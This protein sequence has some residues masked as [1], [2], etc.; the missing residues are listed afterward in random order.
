MNQRKKQTNKKK[1]ERHGEVTVSLSGSSVHISFWLCLGSSVL[2]CA[3][4]FHVY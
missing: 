1:Q 4:V 3:G 2:T